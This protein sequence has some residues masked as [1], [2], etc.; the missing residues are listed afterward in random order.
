MIGNRINRMRI[1]N[2]RIEVGNTLSN[3]RNNEIFIIY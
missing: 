1:E 2:D 3:K